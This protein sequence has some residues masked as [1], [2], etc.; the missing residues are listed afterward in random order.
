MSKSTLQPYLTHIIIP[1]AYR[2]ELFRLSNPFIDLSLFLFPIM[3]NLTQLTTLI[4][5]NIESNYIEQIVNNLSCLPVLSSLIIVSINNI[6]NQNN[7]YYKIFRLP[8]LKYC[9]ILMET[10]GYPK[11]LPVATNEFS[12]MENLVINNEVSIDQ[13]PILLS[14]VPTTTSFI[15]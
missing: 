4:L 7:I 13:L 5:N 3:T 11:P 8:T 10:V 6:R 9:Q 2:I 12:T 14:Y 1:Y 15:Y